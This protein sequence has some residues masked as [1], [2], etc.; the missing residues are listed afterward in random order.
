VERDT[1]YNQ[2]NKA[3]LSNAEA[4]ASENSQRQGL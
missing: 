4:V 3:Q 1:V 2:M